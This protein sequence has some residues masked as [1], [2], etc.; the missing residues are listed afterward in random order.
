MLYLAKEVSVGPD[1]VIE[2]VL[3]SPAYVRV[4]DALNFPLYAR[5][6]PYSFH[7]GM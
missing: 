6:D 5:R 3:T 1:E 4:M 2:V 7:G